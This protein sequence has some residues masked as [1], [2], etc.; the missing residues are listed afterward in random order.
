MS[1]MVGVAEVVVV[2]DRQEA[3]A[4][5]GGGGGEEV[6]AEVVV[7]ADVNLPMN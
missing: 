4:A 5:G 3:G 6:E 7:D 1:M 2:V